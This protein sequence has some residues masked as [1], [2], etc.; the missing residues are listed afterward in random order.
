MKQILLSDDRKDALLRDIQ[1]SFR[2]EFDETISDFRASQIL[3]L[4]V[5]A[6]GPA[7]YNQAVQDVRAH[8]QIKLDDLDGEI[9]VDQ[10]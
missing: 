10:A 4:M 8:L 9:Y 1:A 7:I 5:A 6:L 3:D 2:S